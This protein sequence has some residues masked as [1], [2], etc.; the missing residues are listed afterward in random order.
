V[1][2][3]EKESKKIKRKFVYDGVMYEHDAQC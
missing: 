1:I 2:R 3:S